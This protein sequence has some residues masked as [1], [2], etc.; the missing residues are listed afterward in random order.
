MSYGATTRGDWQRR[1]CCG[2]RF[3]G[4]TEVA[5]AAA[6]CRSLWKFTRQRAYTQSL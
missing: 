4:P 2:N 3:L 6:R 5:A 1:R